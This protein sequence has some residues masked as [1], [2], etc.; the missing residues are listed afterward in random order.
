MKLRACL[1]FVIFFFFSTSLWPSSALLESDREALIF[2]FGEEM[3][4]TVYKDS[5]L[6]FRFLTDYVS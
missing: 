4:V 1:V 3:T 6:T 2:L 5:S